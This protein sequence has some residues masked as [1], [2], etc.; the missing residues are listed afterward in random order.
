MQVVVF[1]MKSRSHSGTWQ[2]QVTLSCLPLTVIAGQD[3]WNILPLFVPMC[4]CRWT[5]NP[6]LFVQ[7]SLTHFFFFVFYSSV[8]LSLFVYLSVYAAVQQYACM[9]AS[10]IRRSIMEV[11][12]RR[13]YCSL[14]K[15]RKDKEGPYSGK[16]AHLK[17][18]QSLLC[19]FY[20]VCM[21]L[22]IHSFHESAKS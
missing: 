16:T 14:T 22:S 4:D 8:F 2:W 6:S 19:V 11:K 9:F 15:S 20:Y 5:N 12:E 10:S 13:P 17:H 18:S 7:L 21:C 1:V 3:H